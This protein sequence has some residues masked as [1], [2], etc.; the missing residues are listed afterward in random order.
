VGVRSLNEV[1]DSV[2]YGNGNVS[3]LR[4]VTGVLAIGETE[5]LN[6][7]GLDVVIIGETKPSVVSE[8]V[9]VTSE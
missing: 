5:T 8:S 9:V 1:S 4:D 6:S 2:I 7:T 3:K